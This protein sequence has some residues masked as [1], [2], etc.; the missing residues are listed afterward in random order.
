M[1]AEE[2]EKWRLSVSTREAVVVD[3]RIIVRVEACEKRR[4]VAWRDS[5]PI[6]VLV[7]KRLL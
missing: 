1:I 6:L 2:L 5:L 4:R 3:V 7:G